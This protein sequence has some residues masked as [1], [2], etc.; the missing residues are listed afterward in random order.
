MLY[1]TELHLQPAVPFEGPDTQGL[2]GRLVPDKGSNLHRSGSTRV[3]AGERA[4]RRDLKF[5][6]DFF[7][8]FK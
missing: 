1:Q 8:A 6:Q 5:A 2:Q 3:I 7:R 4:I